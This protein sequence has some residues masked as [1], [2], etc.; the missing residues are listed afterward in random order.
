MMEWQ[1]LSDG[2]LVGRPLKLSFPLCGHGLDKPLDS[3]FRRNDGSGGFW[4]VSGGYGRRVLSS[5]PA[6]G[7]AYRTSPA[8]C[9]R[10]ARGRRAPFYPCILWAGLRRNDEVR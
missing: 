4:L 6:A 2:T 3:G 5:L 7:R 9:C 1:A 8:V 10:P